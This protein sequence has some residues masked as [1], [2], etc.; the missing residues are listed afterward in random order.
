[1]I[2]N[3]RRGDLVVFQIELTQEVLALDVPSRSKP[4]NRMVFAIPVDLPI[5][6]QSKFQRLFL[7]PRCRSPGA[8][9]W[10]VE[11]GLR[12]NDL[13]RSLLKFNRITSAFNCEFDQLLRKI[14]VT[15]MVN[16]D[17]SNDVSLW[18]CPH[19]LLA[20]TVQPAIPRISST[21]SL[22]TPYPPAVFN[23]VRLIALISAWASAGQTL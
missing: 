9:A 14:Q 19:Y 1:M 17:F 12:V 22:A 3:H 7:L 11:H 15:V 23:T 10:T 4:L 20:E 5:L 6:V 2:C 13:Y 16:T 21:S 18:H 8:L